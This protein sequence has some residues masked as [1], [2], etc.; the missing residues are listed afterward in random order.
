MIFI[1]DLAAEYL[2]NK[3]TTSFPVTSNQISDYS[4]DDKYLTIKRSEIYEYN[5]I[6]ATKSRYMKEYSPLAEDHS[7][8]KIL[9]YAEMNVQPQDQIT[10]K[11]ICYIC[12]DKYEASSKLIVF[13]CDHYCHYDC[14][15]NYC[16]TTEAENHSIGEIYPI[17]C[18]AYDHCLV[19]RL[20]FRLHYVF[21]KDYGFPPEE[22][23]FDNK[24]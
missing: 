9:T 10:D 22:V 23:N 13:P 16:D 14:F 12:F 11:E 20:C 1:Y 18:H 17:I 2:S 6:E 4:K 24:N 3:S 15:K 19:C 21:F 5:K 7:F 8:N